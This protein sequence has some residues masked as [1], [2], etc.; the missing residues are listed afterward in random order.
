MD[1]LSFALYHE[2]NKVVG[3]ETDDATGG[4]VRPRDDPEVTDSSDIEDNDPKRQRTDEGGD[5]ASADI[6]DLKRAV[7]QEV[8][9]SIEGSIPMDDVCVGIDNRDLVRQAI[10]SLEED[11][12]VMQSEGEVYLID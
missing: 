5:D 6:D 9:R 2:N 12:K 3:E 8:S 11:G 10:Q 4:L 7:F 1:T